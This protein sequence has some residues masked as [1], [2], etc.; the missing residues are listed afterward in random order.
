MTQRT[1]SSEKTV[2]PADQGRSPIILLILLGAAALVAALF[3]GQNP[4][5]QRAQAYAQSVA[6]AS[7]GIYVSLRTV[8]AFLSAAQ[9]VEVGGALVVSGTVQP[10]KTLEPID[11][12]IERIASLVFTTMVVTGLLTVAMG[13]VSAVGAGLICLALGL[14]ILD[15]LIGRQ[16]IIVV[17]ARQLTWYGA[18]LAI[19]LPL[20]FL[21]SSLLA[22]RLTQQVW[23][24]NNAV[25]SEITAPIAVDQTDTDGGLWQVVETAE[26]YRKMAGNI[27]DSADDLIGSYIAILAVFLFKIMLL[28]L[29]LTGAFFIIARFFAQRS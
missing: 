21:L 29:L 20:A 23:A 25:I 24:E 22:D 14:W 16:D 7:A 6:V 12:T 28:P 3:H 11:D 19:A 4:L 9:E 10:L 17:M 1:R 18:F 13:P 27:F 8:N 26:D 5:N 2:E 15:R